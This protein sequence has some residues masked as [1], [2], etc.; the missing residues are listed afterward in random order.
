MGPQVS[1]LRP[2]IPL[3]KAHSVRPVLDDT[4]FTPYILY[5]TEDGL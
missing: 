3:V 4:G 2:G 1:R 5:P